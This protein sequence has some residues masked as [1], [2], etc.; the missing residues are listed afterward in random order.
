MPQAQVTADEQKQSR[1]SQI[2]QAVLCGI[3]NG[4]ITIPVMTSFAAIIF[5]VLLQRMS[6]L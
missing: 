6:F 5:Q 2:Q 4:I 3:I 1:A